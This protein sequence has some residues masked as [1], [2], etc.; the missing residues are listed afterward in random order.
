MNMNLNNN[1]RQ[2]VVM[3]IFL[4]ALGVVWW[5]NLWWLLLPAA[6][7][8][9]GVVGYLQR[10]SAGRNDEAMQAALWG[11]GMGLLFLT[12]FVWPGVLFVAGASILLRGRE[13]QVEA[14]VRH[15]IT[16]V[17][18]NRARRSSTERVPVETIPATI[19]PINQSSVSVND[20][21]RLH[22]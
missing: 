13:A 19:I 1:K 3:G 15:A 16:R 2:T 20:T 14:N 9:A 4:I 22:E 12:S 11:I 5:L 6:M 17:R 18:S 8:I 7:I 10:R 21:T